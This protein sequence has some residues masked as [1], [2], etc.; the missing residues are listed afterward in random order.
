MGGYLSKSSIAS[1]NVSVGG[2]IR[3]MGSQYVYNLYV[4]NCH[5]M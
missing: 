2:K 1:G 5:L 3:I 4:N